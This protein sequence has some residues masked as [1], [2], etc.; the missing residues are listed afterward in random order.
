MFVSDPLEE[1]FTTTG[2]VDPRYKSWPRVDT[3]ETFFQIHTRVH[4]ERITD[5]TCLLSTARAFLDYLAACSTDDA[6]T[7]Q[8]IFMVTAPYDNRSKNWK[9]E[10]LL[11]VEVSVD[12][13]GVQNRIVYHTPGRRYSDRKAQKKG[14]FQLK[15][16]YQA[17]RLSRSKSSP[18]A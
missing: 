7:I 9:S 8:Q 12:K 15:T 6:V 13:F 2:K 11:K 17:R 5:E 18:T 16:V 1:V 4:L 10:P 3:S 14:E